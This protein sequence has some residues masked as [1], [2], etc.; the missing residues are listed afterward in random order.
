M[1]ATCYLRIA[2]TVRGYRFAATTKPT[3]DPLRA[4]Y[5]ALPT[6]M[7]RLN[8]E[9][10]ADAF[11]PVDAVADVVL[12]AGMAVVVEADEMPEPEPVAS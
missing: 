3:F 5:D 10:P 12:E 7:V 6:V 9:L 8:L 4:G 1:R 2:R 11:N